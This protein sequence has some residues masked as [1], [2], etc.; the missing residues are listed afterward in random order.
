MPPCFSM[1]VLQAILSPQPP[2]L[3]CCP[4]LAMLLCPCSSSCKDPRIPPIPGTDG[5]AKMDV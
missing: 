3:P 1:G 5:F 4:A 2:C